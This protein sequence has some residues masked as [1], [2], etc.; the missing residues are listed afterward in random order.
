ME[1]EAVNLGNKDPNTYNHG[2]HNKGMTQQQM[3]AVVRVMGN[4]T[5]T[6]AF[7]VSDQSEQDSTAWLFPACWSRDLLPVMLYC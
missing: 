7:R 6:L 1:S 3:M 2:S 4:L 5:F